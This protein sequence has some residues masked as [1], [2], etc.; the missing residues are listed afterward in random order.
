MVWCVGVQPYFFKTCAYLV[1]L[2]SFV[3]MTILPPFTYF[4]TLDKN[5]LAVSVMV[6]FWTFSVL[7]FIHILYLYQYYVV[8]ILLLCSDVWNWDGWVLQ[9]Y[10]S[11]KNFLAIW[12]SLYLYVYFRISLSFSTN[13]TV[14][15]LLGITWNV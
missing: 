4:G 5:Q 14:Q 9:F 6:Y 2:P 12:N 11:L 15:I 1:V 13:E 8:L 7:P 3:E 10:S